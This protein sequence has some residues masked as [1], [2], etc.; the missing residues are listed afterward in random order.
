MKKMSHPLL[1]GLALLAAATAT[2]AIVPTEWRHRQEFTVAAPGLVRVALPDATFDA[3]QPSLADLRLL[4]PEGRETALLLDQPP[5]PAART[6]RPASFDVRLEN[7]SAVATLATGT[8]DPLAA[9]VLET[10]HP[11]FLRGVKIELSADGSTWTTTEEGVPFFRQWGAEK[12]E[13]AL[14]QRS[15]A[16]I[17]LSVSG[18]ALPL[19]GATL[20]L[21]AG[22]AHVPAPV[23]AR[24]ASREE[25]AGET[26]LT[27]ALDGRHAPLSTLQIETPE[28]L[29]MRRV[30]V[31]V[32]DVRDL[33]SSERT[34]G[35]GSVY[36]VALEGSAARAGLDV[37]LDHVPLT[38]ELL[39]HIHNGDSAPLAI[40]Q[41]RLQR[42]PVSLLFMAPV[43]G[44][45][46]LL[47][48]N[49][50][51]T[52]PRYDL[53][54]FA[55]DLRTATAT[56]VTPGVLLDT[57]G[58]QA[59]TS[60]AE[61]PL[62]DIPLVGAPL[63]ARAWTRRK[64]VSLAASGIQELELD[65]AA[66]AGTRADFAD[67]RLLRAGNQIPYVLERPGL[68]RSL[69]LTA[70]FI[71]DP[72]RPTVSI[73]RVKLPHASLPLLRLALASDTVLFQREFRIYQKIST[74]EGR[75]YEHTLA[76]GG[77]HRTPEPG[78]PRTRVF[79]LGGR[80]QADTLFLETDNAD[81]PPLS[82]DSIKGEHAVVRLVF[83]TEATDGFIL[84]YGNPAA[85]APRYDLSLVAV[86]L[87]TAGRSPAR[88]GEEES[89]PE[90]FAR[91][92]LRQLKGGAVFWGALALVVVVLLV[93]VARLL[94]K[95]AT[96]A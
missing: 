85:P 76:T 20:A 3:A 73:W 33:V 55:S 44:T 8:A 18:D 17:R 21:A 70:E 27:L 56:P 37:R 77:W 31:S 25:F 48:G 23:G 28:P 72:K 68:A 29:F 39:V 30:T 60:L 62:P 79:D 40:S 51:A 74:P 86:K 95:S 11:R 32:R 7:G 47:S 12:R 83:K 94:P 10:P 84:A 49:P 59:R 89:D 34:I 15:A 90:G 43:A 65:P 16:W 71:P 50:Q 67:L 63:D 69:P 26:V 35:S 80:L 57:P 4:D 58:Y 82:L 91:G 45:Y 42:R 96:P 13:L 36:R 52:A 6:R 1:N 87:L 22:P 66:L 54:P 38:R 78:S 81:N 53:A 5:T 92:A 88:L 93:V 61:T 41:V 46:R 19:T 2:A 64:A 14:G 75:T 24:I 9:V